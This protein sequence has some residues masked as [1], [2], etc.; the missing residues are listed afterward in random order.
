ME[1]QEL[2]KVDIFTTT[3]G[4][5]ILEIEL[6]L[7]GQ[8][9]F[10]V[11]DNTDFDNLLEGKYGA[12]DYYDESLLSLSEAE[13]TITLYLIDDEDGRNSLDEIK[14]MLGSLRAEDTAGTYGRLECA[15]SSLE[16]EDWEKSWRES[17][18]AFSVGENLVIAP[19]WDTGDFGEKAVIRIEPGGAFG[20]GAD[21]TTRL[22]LE[23]LERALTYRNSGKPKENG[24]I[25]VLDIGSGSGIL[26]IGAVLLG[27]KSALG[28][29]ID[30][31]AVKT[32]KE[33]AE[34]NDVGMHITFICGNLTDYVSE[35]YD[36]VCANII[37]DVII[38]LLPDVPRILRPGGIIIL[39]GILLDREYEVLKRA[40]E[41]GFS[42][43][44]RKEEKGWV[45][46]AMICDT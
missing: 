36:I 10:I 5:D 4:I 26:A 13:T 12:W 8:P 28:I 31:T 1:K 22:S 46:L 14:K 6:T 19:P 21:E 16:N 17:Y 38:T 44:E 24:E 37:A 23:L 11:V 40:A 34:I 30:P 33:N 42:T 43:W 9:S 35:T 20:T 45:C 7:L 39:S 29:D 41:L 15:V 3:E 2:I 18:K 25:K 32:A 27:A